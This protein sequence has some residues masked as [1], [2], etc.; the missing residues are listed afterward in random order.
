MN[1]PA[2]IPPHNVEAEQT[3]IGTMLLS[4]KTVPA[5]MSV[6]R[7][8]DFYKQNHCLI[9]SS[10]EK[11]FKTS[12]GIDF[13]TISDHLKSSGELERAGGP[14][15]LAS[16]TDIIAATSNIKFHCGIV[17][18][19]AKARGII[20]AASSAIDSCFEGMPAGEVF[21]TLSSDLAGASNEDGSN[22]DTVHN[23]VG[24]VLTEVKGLA[25]GTIKETGVKTGF[26]DLDNLTRGFQKSDLIILAGR[27]SMGKTTLAMNMVTNAARI[28]ARV[29]IF[30]LEMSRD[31]LVKKQL[32]SV[33]GVNVSSIE[34][35][36]TL[37]ETTWPMLNKAAGFVGKLNM[38]IDDSSSLDIAQIQARAKME[39]M[40][41]GLDMVMVDYLQLARAGSFRNNREREVSE[42]SAGL[43]ALAKDLKIPVVALSQLSRKCEE[44]TDKRPLMSDLRDSGSIEQDADVIAFVYRDEVYNTSPDN[45]LKGEAELLIR[46]NRCG[47]IGTVKMSF[48]GACCRFGNLAY[49]DEY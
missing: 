42:I 39:H 29:M 33:S 27:P 3:V 11:L 23:I 45:P 10:M 46:K 40:K 43:K 38:T 21:S 1:A 41:S 20:Y 17:R 47:E 31:K 7:S 48:D 16:L 35:G 22:T 44:R 49:S 4:P 37:N 2:R 9:F 24:D 5:V 25:D 14:A 8:E 6:L 15:Y 32:S 19:H 13:V 18:E 12:A 34:K 30:S 26:V 28:G 36:Y